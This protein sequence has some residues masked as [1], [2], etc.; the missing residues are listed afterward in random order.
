MKYCIAFSYMDKRPRLYTGLCYISLKS[1]YGHG[2][3]QTS[4]SFICVPGIMLESEISSFLDRRIHCSISFFM[5]IR[6]NTTRA[7]EIHG[8]IHLPRQHL[9]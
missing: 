4:F 3:E 8:F 9:V 7:L 6:K 5:N 2:G 1:A